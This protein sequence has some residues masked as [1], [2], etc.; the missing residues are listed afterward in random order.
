MW[1][2]VK[3]VTTKILTAGTRKKIML[4][5]NQSAESTDGLGLGL[6]TGEPHPKNPL[7]ELC[8][9]VYSFQASECNQLQLVLSG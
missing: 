1:Q 8:F 6:R 7:V 5:V 2:L 9:N 3:S 4:Y